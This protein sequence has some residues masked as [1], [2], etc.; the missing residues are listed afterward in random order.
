[1]LCVPAGSGCNCFV[2]KL[3]LSWWWWWW[4]AVDVSEIGTFHKR[5]KGTHIGHKG[6]KQ[7]WDT[8]GYQRVQSTMT[9]T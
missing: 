8:K 4:L 5:G 6:I 2:R 7:K 9:I 1:M 3:L